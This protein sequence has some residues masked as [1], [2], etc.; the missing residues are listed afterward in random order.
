MFHAI[1]FILLREYWCWKKKTVRELVFSPCPR[2][3]LW[4]HMMANWCLHRYGKEEVTTKMTS[5]WC[6]SK[7]VWLSLFNGWY[8]GAGPESLHG[9]FYYWSDKIH[10]LSDSQLTFAS[11]YHAQPVLWSALSG[12]QRMQMWSHNGNELSLLL[13][14]TRCL[15]ESSRLSFGIYVNSTSFGDGANLFSATIFTLFTD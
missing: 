11:L 2:W 4:K 7:T 12:M 1:L 5:R 13:T 14:H 8:L 6:A 15:W 3:A 9:H 10:N